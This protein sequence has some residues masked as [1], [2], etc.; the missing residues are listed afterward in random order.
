MLYSLKMVADSL[1]GIH[2][3]GYSVVRHLAQTKGMGGILCITTTGS[4]VKASY[5]STEDYSSTIRL[6]IAR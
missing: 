2:S 4:S 1:R 6:T 5:K 3:I